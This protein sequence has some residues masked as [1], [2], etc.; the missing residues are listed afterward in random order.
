LARIAEF[1]RGGAIL[2]TGA[3]RME[4]EKRAGGRDRYF[5][6]IEILDRTG[7]LAE[8]YDKHRLVPFGEFMPFQSW[9]ERFGVTQFVQI[10]GGFDRG[11]GTNVIHVPGLPDA[12]A[13]VCYE[14][15]F[16]NE[17]GAREGEARH[18]AWLLNL[19]DDAWFGLTAGPYQH[20]AQARLRAIELGL[21]LVRVADTGVSAVVDPEGRILVSAPLGSEAVLDSP[22]PGARPPTWQSRWGSATF[23]AGLLATLL[24]SLSA[25]RSRA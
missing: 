22:L 18:V 4:E 15:I 11:V 25:R 14:A 2:V 13:M 3:A 5:N 12:L 21:P 6:S 19:T 9:L 7:L 20:F 16:P 10:P 17:L 24:A 8:R 23:A 1:L